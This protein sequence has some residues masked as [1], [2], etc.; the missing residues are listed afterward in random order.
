[1]FLDLKICLRLQDH[2]PF[3]M[4]PPMESKHQDKKKED[5]DKSDNIMRQFIDLKSY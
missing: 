5:M 2:S 1:M 4:T 3:I